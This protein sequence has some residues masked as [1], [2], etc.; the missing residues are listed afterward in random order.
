MVRN[1]RIPL[2]FAIELIDTVSLIY[3]KMES[4]FVV[5]KNVMTHLKRSANIA[6]RRKYVRD[7]AAQM[8]NVASIMEDLTG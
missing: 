3:W 7:H 5:A 1:V 4:N 2:K 8:E 6:P